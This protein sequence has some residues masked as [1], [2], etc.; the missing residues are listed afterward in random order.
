MGRSSAPDEN[1]AARQSQAIG[2]RLTRFRRQRGLTQGQLAKRVGL[3]QRVMSYYERGTT[4]IPAD[5]LLKIADVLHVSV[6][7]LLGRA[8][9]SRPTVDKRLWKV[10]ERI[11]ALP[12]QELRPL[13]R[14]I[15][16]YLKSA[17]SG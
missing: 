8:T 3:T 4:R 12:P 17:R 9:T 10:V 6:Y 2:D 1:G 16:G 14:V 5:M 7:E 13:L 11:Q 15:D